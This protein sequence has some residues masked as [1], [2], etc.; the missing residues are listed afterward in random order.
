MRRVWIGA[1][2]LGIT[3]L[4]FF[5]FPGHT[6]LQSDTQIYTPIL[7]HLWNPA[8]LEKDLIAQHPHVA[9]TLYDETA[10]A[11][12][13]ATG[14]DFRYVLEAEQF[15]G[16]RAGHLGRVPDRHGAWPFRSFG[17]DGSG[18]I[19]A[20]RDDPGPVSAAV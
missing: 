14:L 12:R 18:D 17:A 13:Q 11:L 20:G 3:L 19:L 16:P 15:V 4:N 2:I 9:F 5:Q 10:L 1:A 6:W 8:V 7:E